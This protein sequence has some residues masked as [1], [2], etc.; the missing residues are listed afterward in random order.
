MD[1]PPQLQRILY[2]EDEPDIR[3]IAT[4][5]LSL[6]GGFEVRSCGSGAEA[7]V[8]APGFGP[9]L[10]LLDVM[11]PDMDGV[12]TASALHAHP[13]LAEVPVVFMTARLQDRDLETYRREG[14]LG[15]I[16]KPFEPLGL[17]GQVRELW[18]RRG[19]A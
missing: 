5:A 7:V 9:D 18:E 19:H 6:V 12:A 17:A 11:M 13:G 2:V 14:A 16:A 3:R 10:F 15:V 8:E 1:V 4:T